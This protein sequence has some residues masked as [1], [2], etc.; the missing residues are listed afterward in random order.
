MNPVLIT[1]IGI[2]VV[3]SLFFLILLYIGRPDRT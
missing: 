2:G 3:V 1:A